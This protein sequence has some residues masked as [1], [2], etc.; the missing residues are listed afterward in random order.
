MFEGKEELEKLMDELKLDMEFM[1]A[2]TLPDSMSTRSLHY[3]MKN[4]RSDLGVSTFR[5][6]STYRPKTV[7]FTDEEIQHLATLVDRKK[8]LKDARPVVRIRPPMQNPYR[9]DK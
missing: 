3:P 8:L 2:G 9:S 1:Q 6:M 4:P 5:R 7:V